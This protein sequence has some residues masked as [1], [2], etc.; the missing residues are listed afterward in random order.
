[1]PTQVQAQ[2]AHADPAE[3][4]D[5]GIAALTQGAWERA[6]AALQQSISGNHRACDA[7]YFVGVLACL[8]GQQEAAVRMI[9]A[10]AHDPGISD[11]FY[12]TLRQVVDGLGEPTGEDLRKFLQ[13][14]RLLPRFVTGKLGTELA[15]VKIEPWY[16]SRR[17]THLFPRK[18]D[19]FDDEA[20]LVEKYILPGWLPERPLFTR[21]SSLL[22]MGSCFAEELRNYLAEE[23]MNS[24]WMFVPPGLN[25]TFAIK[26]FVDWCLTGSLSDEAYWY[27]EVDGGAV[28][29]APAQE[30]DAYRAVFETIDGL[31]LT[32]GLAEVWYDTDTGGVFWRGVPKSLYDED[33]HLCR[34][35]TVAENVQNLSHTIRT[36]KAARPDLP[37]ILTL[38]PIPLKATFEPRSCFTV[39][40]VSKSTLRV[41]IDAIMQEGHEGLYYWPS[42]EIVRWLGGHLGHGMFGEDGNTR[43]V[44]RATVKLILASFFKHYFADTVD[45]DALQLEGR[46]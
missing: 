32:I 46:Q 13:L 6:H 22:T 11:G 8:C 44:N 28:K 16:F 24:G 30:S 45:A 26:N 5:A 12:A 19:E 25:N 29:W 36:L 1:M 35:S 40:C 15:S 3:A 27:D 38:S 9:K 43:H 7:R 41:A 42:F 33:K 10:V 18:N 4:F 21:A 2:Q 20:R 23:G 34:M 37:I 17:A 31:V 39:D 14:H